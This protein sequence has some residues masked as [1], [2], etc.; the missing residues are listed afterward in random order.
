MSRESEEEGEGEKERRGE[1]RERDRE[2][3][4]EE[5][6]IERE[7]KENS[8]HDSYVLLILQCIFARI[9]LA[10]QKYSGRIPISIRTSDVKVHN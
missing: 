4:T 3:K 5:R 8:S 6:E 10:L 1:G 9:L 7:K 2:R